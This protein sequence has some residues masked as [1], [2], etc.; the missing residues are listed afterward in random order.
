VRS[1]SGRSLAVKA[2][3]R[4]ERVSLTVDDASG[5]SRLRVKWA[6]RTAWVKA[7][8]IRMRWGGWKLSRKGS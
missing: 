4:A 7:P 5:V 1:G 6:W 2:A 3:D 8:M